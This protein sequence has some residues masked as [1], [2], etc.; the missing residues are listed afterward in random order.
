[1]A[2]TKKGWDT[3]LRELARRQNWLEGR[4][5]GQ[6]RFNNGLIGSLEEAA[7]SCTDA[8]LQMEL[9]KLA[10]DHKELMQEGLA[11]LEFLKAEHVKQREQLRQQ[12]YGN[13]S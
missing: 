6:I 2:T 13:H 7:K 9:E 3:P 10:L 11:L 5:H 8:L 4:L 1:M 12:L